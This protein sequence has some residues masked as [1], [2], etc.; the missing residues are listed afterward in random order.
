MRLNQEPRSL[1][2]GESSGPTA[3]QPG[4]Q[5]KQDPIECKARIMVNCTGMIITY[6]CTCLRAYTSLS[7]TPFW[8]TGTV[9]SFPEKLTAQKRAACPN[10]ENC[11]VMGPGVLS[12]SPPHPPASHGLFLS[13]ALLIHSLLAAVSCVTET[14]RNFCLAFNSEEIPVTGFPLLKKK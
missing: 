9:S 2:A 6:M 3:N 1:G 11:F 8:K 4:N 10:Q 14:A 7:R 13:A 12:C 5:T